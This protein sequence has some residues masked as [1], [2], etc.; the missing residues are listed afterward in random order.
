[1][2][3]NLQLR[4]LSLSLQCCLNEGQ[5]FIIALAALSLKRK[6]G[7]LNV[8]STIQAHGNIKHASGI[9]PV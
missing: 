6:I 4:K 9:F 7:C 1:M 2:K 5:F 8:R 3:K